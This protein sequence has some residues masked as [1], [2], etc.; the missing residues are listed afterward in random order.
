[1]ALP[2]LT[3]NINHYMG[4]VVALIGWLLGW[5]SLVLITADYKTERTFPKIPT[6]SQ[7]YG[8]VFAVGIAVL[9]WFQR[10]L[11]IQGETQK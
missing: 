9:S 11:S 10:I 2:D 4:L 3:L 1:M 5:Y 7:Y 8:I 6:S